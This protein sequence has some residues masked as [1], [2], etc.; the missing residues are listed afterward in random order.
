MKQSQYTLISHHL[1]PYVQRA[2]I[3]LQE[4]GILFERRNIDLA[5]KPEWFLK[6]SPLGKVPLLLVD[7]DT[8]IFES[9]VIA[10]YINEI[11]G[12]DLLATDPVRR[13]RQRSWIEFASSALVNIG[14]FYNAPN[15]TTFIAARESLANKWRTLEANIA[16]NDWFSGDQF[17][18]VDAAFAPVFRYFD[19]I[20]PLT[21]INFFEG[22]PKLRQWRE[23]LAARRSVQ[24]AVGSDYPHRLREFLAN[25]NSIV[26]NLARPANEAAA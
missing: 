26:G 23:N 9:S 10:E 20:E 14:Q 2:A 18:L 1:C 15:E 25:R 16:N 7:D 21:G 11:S 17:S 22:L 6:L 5:N 8:V 13:A 24:N 12:G 3:A 4:K 19:V